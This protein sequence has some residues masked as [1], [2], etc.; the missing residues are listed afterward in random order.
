MV[1]VFVSSLI[2]RLIRYGYRW[3]PPELCGIQ[4]DSDGVLLSA[5]VASF[6]LLCRYFHMRVG[7]GFVLS[8]R[9]LGKG[10]F[11]YAEGP[12]GDV[13]CFGRVA[14]GFVV[15]RD[16]RGFCD[17]FLAAIVSADV[18]WGSRRDLRGFYVQFLVGVE[19][20]RRPAA[21]QGGLVPAQAQPLSLGPRQ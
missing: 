12:S 7:R 10:S 20:D 15:R 2:D 21:R 1:L 4:A 11:P 18:V 17:R 19:R 14:R 6:G 16:L 8:A 9:S 3:K 5:M 13:F